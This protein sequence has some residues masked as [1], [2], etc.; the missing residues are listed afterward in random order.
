MWMSWEGM[1]MKDKDRL[2]YHEY[3]EIAEK[4]NN[5]DKEYAKFVY[6][7]E[8]PY[9]EDIWEKI[10]SNIEEDDRLSIV[11]NI[12]QDLFLCRFIIDALLKRFESINASE[13]KSLRGVILTMANIERLLISPE[14]KVEEYFIELIKIAEG[15]VSRLNHY[16]PTMQTQEK[17]LKDYFEQ[18]KFPSGKNK[19]MRAKWVNKHGQPVYDLLKT[20]NCPCNYQAF[21]AWNNAVGKE[22]S[23]PDT[24]FYHYPDD[25]RSFLLATLHNTTPENIKKY[26]KKKKY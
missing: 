19:D 11:N 10:I 24:V 12:P 14:R 7:I 18:E 21:E 13:G 3:K 2:S 5:P 20:F 17:A 8:K 1:K 16:P 22:A 6:K 15:R 26:L 23:K 4:T 9:I 25:V